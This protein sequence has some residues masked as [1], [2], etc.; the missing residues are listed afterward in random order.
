MDL[1]VTFLVTMRR[2]LLRKIRLENNKTLHKKWN[3]KE[4]EMS[5]QPMVLM[6]NVLFLALMGLLSLV[7]TSALV[8]LVITLLREEQ[9]PTFHPTFE[10]E[11]A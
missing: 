11:D 4:T 10:S 1:S 3:G 5:A 2:Y 9:H 8:E 7:G 6:L